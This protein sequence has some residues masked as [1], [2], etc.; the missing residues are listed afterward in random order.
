MTAS[1]GTSL[2]VGMKLLLRRMITLRNDG[3]VATAP[4]PHPYPER[5]RD[6]RA[7]A[8]LLH[9]EDQSWSIEAIRGE[10]LPHHRSLRWQAAGRRFVIKYNIRAPKN[11]YSGGRRYAGVRKR[12]YRGERVRKPAGI[13]ATRDMRHVW[14]G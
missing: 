6:T 9:S 4:R 5:N 7:R 3:T 2:S 1:D 12:P 10:S 13:V 11:Q 8:G 14:T